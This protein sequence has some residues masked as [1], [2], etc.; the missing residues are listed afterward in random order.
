MDLDSRRSSPNIRDIES[1]TIR[2][3]AMIGDS[4]RVDA[5]GSLNFSQVVE[6]Q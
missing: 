3:T 5:V 1:L 4:V 6:L 2:E